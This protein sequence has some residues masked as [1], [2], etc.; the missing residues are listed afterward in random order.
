MNKS[1]GIDVVV[2]RLSYGKL[3]KRGRSGSLA[4]MTL[5]TVIMIEHTLIGILSNDIEQVCPFTDDLLKMTG[6]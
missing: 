5:W 3:Y 6:I 1:L 2:G 4:R